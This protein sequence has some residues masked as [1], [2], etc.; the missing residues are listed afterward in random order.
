[1]F[2][3]IQEVGTNYAGGFITTPNVHALSVGRG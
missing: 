1:M 3:S 2:K